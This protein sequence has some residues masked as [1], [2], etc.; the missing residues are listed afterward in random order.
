MDQEEMAKC[1][2]K[3]ARVLPI[4]A[5]ES[6]ANVVLQDSTNFLWPALLAKQVLCKGRGR[7][8]GNVL[9]LGNRQNLLLCEV[10]H[11]NAVFKRDHNFPHPSA[12]VLQP[13]W[14]SRS[15][16]PESKSA[17]SATTGA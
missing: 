13:I 2:E 11:C 6:G 15:T 3:L 12:V 1:H 14:S 10:A 7:D 5:S 8:F 16:S 4:A 9:V 17:N